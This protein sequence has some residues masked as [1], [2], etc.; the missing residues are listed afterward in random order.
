MRQR[1]LSRLPGVA[2]LLLVGVPALPV[3]ADDFPLRFLDEPAAGGY[4]VLCPVTVD[5]DGE[6]RIAFDATETAKMSYLRIAGGS[7]ALYHV[8]DAAAERVGAPRPFGAT[9]DVEI[10]VQRRAGRVRVIAAGEVLLDVPW[11]APIGGKVGVGSRGA[12]A[13]GEP[14]L[15]RVP[16][17]V[18][19]DDFTRDAG[20][21]GEWETV[22]GGFRNTVVQA[23]GAEPERSANP[24]SLHVQGDGESLATSGYW[25]WDSYHTSASV[26][27]RD[28]REVGLCAYVQD[29]ASYLALRW[30]AGGDAEPGAR[31]IVL[32]RGGE[33]RI[34]AEAAGGFEPEQWYRLELRVVPGR[35]EAL[36]DRYPALAADTTAFGQGGIGLWTRGGEAVFDDARVAAPDALD[37]HGP[38]IN[39][40]F[41]ADRTM[42]ENEVFVS[43]G[44]WRRGRRPGEYWHWGEFFDDA[45]VAVPVEL[46]QAEA[47]GVLLRSDATDTVTGYRVRASAANG[48]VTLDAA[49]NGDRVAGVTEPLDGEHPLL[50]AVRGDTLTVSQGRRILLPY[51]DAE[52]ILGRSVALLNAP[53]AAVD[54]VTITSDHFR[55]YPFASGPTDWFAA[56]GTWDLTTRWPCEL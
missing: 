56:K 24:F 30:R 13:A 43:R 39:P 27:P 20:E 53:P 6:L 23:E 52:P 2:V 44:F 33:E 37:I 22:G 45:T 49:R 16:E 21:M 32:V 42:T 25:F 31:R 4:S 18:F 40:V 50:F 3:A 7:A 35:V 26:K 55:D 38:R 36:I 15:Q 29:A 54:L 19:E 5:G 12:L 28:A 11:D 47:L 17:P 34:L 14:L 1:R 48:R 51:T 46:L 41:V 10:T 8:A 9:G